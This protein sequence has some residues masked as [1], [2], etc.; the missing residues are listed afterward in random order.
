MEGETM[1]ARVCLCAVGLLVLAGQGKIR[2]DDP[3][4]VRNDGA[5]SLSNLKFTGDVQTGDIHWGRGYGYGYR[6]YGYRG[7]GYGYRGY[8]YGYRGYGYGYGYGLGYRGY[9]GNPYF[10]AAAPY[11]GY[12]GYP[13]G[14][15]YRC[16]DMIDAGPVASNL[17]TAPRS[18]APNS[19]VA[20]SVVKGPLPLT[21]FVPY[22][23]APDGSSV[24]VGPQGAADRSYNYNGGPKAIVPSPNNSGGSQPFFIPPPTVDP[25]RPTIPRDGYLTALPRGMTGEV[26]P[27]VYHGPSAARPSSAVVIGQT[28]PQIAYP[29]YGDPR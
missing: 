10:Y 27:V 13:Y 3:P 14:Y 22:S 2:A 15:G 8:G 5:A 4:L 29:A 16:I 25:E 20:R 28:A 23:L 26:S 12:G 1:K 7:Y 9:Y 24:G 17:G 6:G 21:D 11:Y 19:S 18:I